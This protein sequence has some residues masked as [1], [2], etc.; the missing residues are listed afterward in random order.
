M[1]LNKDF[2]IRK[3]AGDIILVPVGNMAKKYNGLI[4]IN[5][6]TEFIWNML[7]QDKTIL[8]IVNAIMKE[9]DGTSRQE[10]TNDV[11]EFIQVLIKHDILEI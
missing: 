1:K 8:E 5:D 9:F 7:L 4:A 6:V 3:I 11:N 2:V 10:V